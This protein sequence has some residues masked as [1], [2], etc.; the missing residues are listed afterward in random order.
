[1]EAA[2]SVGRA[3]EYVAAPLHAARARAASERAAPQR[4]HEIACVPCV[5]GGAIVCWCSGY[6]MAR[7]HL[8]DRGKNSAEV[9]VQRDRE[10]SALVAV[11]VSD[12]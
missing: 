3:A 7:G 9:K 10:V 4:S 2:N 5:C 12:P 11:V 1:M 6:T 8:T